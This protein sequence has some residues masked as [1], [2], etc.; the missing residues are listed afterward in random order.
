ME[1]ST[2]NMMYVLSIFILLCGLAIAANA[3]IDKAFAEGI[4]STGSG[5]LT[6]MILPGVEYSNSTIYENYCYA[7]NDYYGLRM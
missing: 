3:T 5:L 4:R 2:L 7:M 1:K 6:R